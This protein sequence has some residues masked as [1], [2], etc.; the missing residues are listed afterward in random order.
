MKENKAPW[1]SD[2]MSLEVKEGILHCHYPKGL[3]IDLE[4]AEKMVK[5]RAE[6]TRGTSYPALVDMSNIKHVKSQAMKYLA[7][8]VAYTDL[9][10]I[11]IYSSGAILSKMMANLWLKLD[12]PV[13]PTK[14][15]TDLPSAQIFLAETE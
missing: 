7:S 9:T 10:R 8:E 5:A 15:F 1:H 6:Y 2:L 13:K 4:T 3:T 12:S 14:Y 11:A